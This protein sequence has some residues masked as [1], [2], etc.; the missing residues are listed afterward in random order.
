MI[1]LTIL[2]KL[3]LGE[4]LLDTFRSTVC[5]VGVNA[6]ELCR[7][8][9]LYALGPTTILVEPLPRH[10]DALRKRFPDAV[11]I[12]AAIGQKT[13]K[14][15][16]RD[17][18]QCS[19]FEDQVYCPGHVNKFHSPD[20]G[21]VI[22]V[23]VVRFEEIDPGNIDLIAVDTEGAEWFVLQTMR[24]RPKAIVLET[25]LTGFP[26]KNPHMAEILKWMNQNGY[27]KLCND[28][29]DTCWVRIP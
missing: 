27:Q 2:H 26:Y 17:H 9:E 7:V 25:H 11:V 5:E 21:E 28:E 16:F 14:A 20:S 29:S 6:P 3:I 8:A 4:R 18:E 12:G 15:Q 24:S 22:E 23:P 1:D 13:G 19:H 10:V